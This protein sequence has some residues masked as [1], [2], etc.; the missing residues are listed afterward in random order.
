M[1]TKRLI[2]AVVLFFGLAFVGGGLYS[3][4]KMHEEREEKM[5]EEHEGKMHEEHKGKAHEEKAEEEDEIEL[6]FDDLA[7]GNIPQGWKVEATNQKGPLA[8]W[9][10][11][12]DT[13]A[14]SGQHVLALTKPNHTF[15]GTFNLLWT[16]QIRFLNGEIEVDFKANSGVEDQGGGVIWRAQDKDNYY[17]SRYNP[18]ENNFR[19]YYVKDGARRMLASAL[20]KLPAHKWHELKIVQ[21]GNKISGY[22]N[23]KK[24]LEVEDSTFA[25]AGGVGLW[26]KADAVTSF[27]NFDV[28]FEEAE[29]D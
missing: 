20:V 8:T 26:T 3:Q 16:D 27:D 2:F 19:I 6:S 1:C 23:D 12:K 13:T 21:Q 7:P 10:V 14:P 4:E 22:L 11:V 9:Q 28:E 18:L 17:I 24:L 29:H 15:G 25:R 5:H